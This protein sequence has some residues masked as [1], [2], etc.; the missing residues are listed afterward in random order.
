MP[1]YAML[2]LHP[3]YYGGDELTALRKAFRTD[4]EALGIT[5]VKEHN[6]GSVDVLWQS[7]G[8]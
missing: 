3:S 5:Y 8:I 4:A 7:W 2:Q 1:R 6:E